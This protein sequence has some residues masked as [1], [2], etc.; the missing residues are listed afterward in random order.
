MADKLIKIV[1]DYFSALRDAHRLGAG[2]PERTYYPAVATLM[3]AIGADLKGRVICLSDLEN[4]GAGHPDFGLYAKSQLQS[5]KPR[6]GQ[7]PE[8][9]VIEMKPVADDAWL[10]ARVESGHPLFRDLPARH[11]H[12]PARFP[13][14]RRR[15]E[16]AC[17]EARTLPPG[18][19][20]RL[21]L[22]ARLDAAQIGGAR[23]PRVRR[24]PYARA[25]TIRGAARAEGP[26]LVSGLLCPRCPGAGRG[27]GDLPALATVRS[28]LE[29][30]LGIKFEGDKG[31]HF[32]R[33][34]LVQTLFYGVFSAWVLWARQKPPADAAASTG[35]R[36]SGTCTC[37]SSAR[38]SSSWPRR[39]SCSR[40][41][42]SRCSTGPR[43]TLNRVDRAA[44]FERFDDADAVQ[45]FYEPFLEA[46]DPELRKRARRLV[47]A[48][49]DRHAT[50]SRASTRCCARSWA[51]PMA[52][53]TRQRLRARPVLRHRRLPGRGPAPHRRARSASRGDG[54]PDGRRWS[55]RRRCSACSA[56][57]SCRRR[58]SSRTCSS[59]CCCSELGAPLDSEHRARRRLPDQRPDRL[60][61][62]DAPASR[63]RSRSWRRS[64]T[65][66]SS[67]KQE[68]ADPRRSSAT[69]RTTA[70]PAWRSARSAT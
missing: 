50:W 3:N 10:K 36:P 13:H 33:S 68:R 70:S 23:R 47:H 8:R 46:F 66:P 15:A 7:M 44:F 26:R 59:G 18:Q 5:G 60:G 21:V 14:H 16:R 19:R 61:S 52:W 38:C 45:Y 63:C 30:A 4:V 64:A 40:S 1:E 42:W 25:H 20:R 49:R 48:A 28:A 62:R 57:R 39:A 54:A 12:Q 31:E 55:S 29:E 17:G 2:T 43:P 58:S 41:A 34:T 11:R 37:R 56:S 27:C 24:V 35:R 69:R 51:S 9:G 6:K 65:R 32:F 67:V 22:E 53:P